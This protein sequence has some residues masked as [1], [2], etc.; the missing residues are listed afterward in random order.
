MWTCKVLDL[1]RNANTLQFASERLRDDPE[2]VLKVYVCFCLAMPI[3]GVMLPDEGEVGISSMGE[4]KIAPG[5]TTD[6]WDHVYESIKQRGHV[7]LWYVR[8]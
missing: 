5:R 7:R 8:E 3:V 6:S 4:S 2:I 1:T